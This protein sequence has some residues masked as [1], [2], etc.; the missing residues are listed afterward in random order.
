MLPMVTGNRFFRR[1]PEIV[2]L[3]K[4]VPFSNAT[5]SG[6]FLSS[7][8]AGMKYMFAIECSNPKATNAVIGKRMV[9]YFFISP[10]GLVNTCYFC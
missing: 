3:E 6:L 10:F 1:N 2:R 9:F 7:R 5:M 8:P 4:S